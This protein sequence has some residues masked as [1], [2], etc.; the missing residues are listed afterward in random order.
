MDAFSL[1]VSAGTANIIKRQKV[2]LALSIGIMH[3][4][5]PGI[6]V[7]LG[8]HLFRIL[9]LSITIFNVL[10]F[11]YLGIIMFFKKD[12]TKI[13]RY[14]L[15]NT[16]I[17]AICVSV[18]SFT[19]GLGLSDI[20][21]YYLLASLSFGMISG[22]VSYLGLLLGERIFGLLKEQ[23][24]KLGALILFLLAIVNLMRELF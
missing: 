19:I 7:I 21:R 4:I 20:T 12:D 9:P 11:T 17:L 14:S 1:S 13:F 24:T 10:I 5:M 8:H 16:L 15:I 23:A 3:F 2:V 18:D 6:G 22:L